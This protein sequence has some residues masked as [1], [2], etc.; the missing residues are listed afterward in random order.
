MIDR[1]LDL[2][3][4]LGRDHRQRAAR[5]IIIANVVGIVAFVAQP[6]EWALWHAVDQVNGDLRIVRLARRDQQAKRPAFGIGIGMKF[7]REA[8]ARAAKTLAMSPPFAPAA[9]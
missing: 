8:T 7:G 5:P 6:G 9:Q 4:R 2:A 3:G 1:E